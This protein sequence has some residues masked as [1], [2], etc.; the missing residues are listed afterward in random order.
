MLAIKFRNRM[1]VS[2]KTKIEIINSVFDIIEVKKRTKIFY[3]DYTFSEVE[4]STVVP[5]IDDLF[6]HNILDRLDSDHFITFTAETS[7]GSVRAE[8]NPTKVRN[9]IFNCSHID[10]NIE[11]ETFLYD[12][13]KE[14]NKIV[15]LVESLDEYRDILSEVYFFDLNKSPDCYSDI[16][17]RSL[18]K[19]YDEVEFANLLLKDYK[20]EDKVDEKTTKAIGCN[21]THQIFL[22]HRQPFIQ[23]I[24]QEHNLNLVAAAGSLMLDGSDVSKFMSI[25]FL[26]LNLYITNIKNKDVYNTEFNK[27]YD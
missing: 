15:H 7:Y 12:I 27:L 9:S 24:I 10:I 18:L 17:N 4:E 26:K 22:E 5:L 6:E 14:K 21:F 19:V 20:F 25:I 11:N 16:S 3:S 23:N 2:V 13:L 8:I 1:K